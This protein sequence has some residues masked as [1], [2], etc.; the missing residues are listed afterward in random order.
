MVSKT[1]QTEEIKDESAQMKEE[2]GKYF[3]DSLGNLKKYFD[4]LSYEFVQKLVCSGFG[5]HNTNNVLPNFLDLL[6]SINTV[7]V[8]NSNLVNTINL[9]NYSGRNVPND[10]SVTDLLDN[11]SRGAINNDFANLLS[12]LM[13]NQTTTISSN[14]LF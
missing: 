11:N 10:T 3:L 14:S 1:V 12:S 4:Q 6:K 8:K 5:N 9:F 2:I 13:K 7:N